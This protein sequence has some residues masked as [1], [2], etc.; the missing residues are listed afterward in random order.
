LSL[1]DFSKKETVYQRFI[2][3]TR[4]I[5]RDNFLLTNKPVIALSLNELSANSLFNL[6]VLTSFIRHNTIF[7][8][9]FEE[10][11]DSNGNVFA[12]R[13]PE[14]KEIIM[15]FANYAK[16]IKNGRKKVDTGEHN[17]KEIGY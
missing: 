17:Y 15:S 4:Y 11:I 12:D 7:H 3:R 2:E 14:L 16:I 13:K 5:R 9:G 10:Y 8:K 1:E 6:R